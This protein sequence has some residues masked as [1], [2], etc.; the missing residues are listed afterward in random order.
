[1]ELRKIS[2]ISYRQFIEEKFEID[3]AVAVIVGRNEH[4]QDWA[5]R[6]SK[7]S[8]FALC[9]FADQPL[10][11]ESRTLQFTRISSDWFVA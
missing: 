4:R 11:G 5:P 9:S 1:M 6:L 7:V 2:F 8:A 3:P 10:G